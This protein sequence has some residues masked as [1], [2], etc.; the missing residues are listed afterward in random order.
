MLPMATLT[1][2]EDLECYRSCR[3]YR[4]HVAVF[5]KTLPQAEEFRLKSQ[6]LRAARS[7]TANIA[8][9]FGRHHHQENLQYCRQARGS[10]TETL[11][12]LNVGLDEG[13]MDQAT[14]DGLKSEQQA[15]AQI[16]N[17]YI[18]YLKKAALR[19]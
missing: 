15:A 18:S 17:G 16:L 13:L 10:L 2:F 12:H 3:R 1:S 4:I 5:C 8:E 14:Y 7:V 19:K 6:L 9:G 11:D